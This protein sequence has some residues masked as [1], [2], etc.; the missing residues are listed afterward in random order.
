MSLTITSFN[1]RYC[2]TEGWFNGEDCPYFVC[3]V[4]FKIKRDEDYTWERAKAESEEY[5]RVLTIDDP[6][7]YEAWLVSPEGWDLDKRYDGYDKAWINNDPSWRYIEKFD[8][9]WFRE[10][11]ADSTV[12]R[13]LVSE[14][15]H[16]Y[17]HGK[18]PSVYRTIEPEI[19]LKHLRTLQSY[20]D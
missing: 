13:A 20:W 15:E 12:T 16:Y 18:L 19:V 1:V 10:W 11:I 2:N 5:S 6:E 8:C 7:R 9:Y 3:N 17:K 4:V 14:L